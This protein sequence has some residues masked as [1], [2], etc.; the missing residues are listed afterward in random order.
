[1]PALVSPTPLRVRTLR[2]PYDTLLPAPSTPSI[3]VPP[4]TPTLPAT[5][6]SSTLSSRHG[7]SRADSPPCASPPRATRA[8]PPLASPRCRLPGLMRTAD[9][10]AAASNHEGG[11]CSARS[12][13]SGPPTTAPPA[14]SAERHYGSRLKKHPGTPLQLPPELSA[15]LSRTPPVPPTLPATAPPA[16]GVDPPSPPLPPSSSPSPSLLP[17]SV[18]P[19]EYHVREALPV[20]PEGTG[21]YAAEWDA[22]TERWVVTLFPAQRPVGREQVAH[23]RNCLNRMIGAETASAAAAGSVA[24]ERPTVLEVRRHHHDPAAM[25]RA[26]ASA[27]SP[28]SRS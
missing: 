9:P 10:A 11:W 27:L 15:F 28:R 8:S 20:R 14:S 24:G 18:L 13:H 17:P 21:A 4:P 7:L 22:E 6:A 1:M 25:A 23:L 16:T 3:P 26:R 5:Y 19:T 12:P 2:F